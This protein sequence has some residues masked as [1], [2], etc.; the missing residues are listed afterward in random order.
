MMSAGSQPALSC[1]ATVKGIRQKRLRH[2]TCL[3]NTVEVAAFSDL[4]QGLA[5][6][7]GDRGAEVAGGGELVADE[8]APGRHWD[9]SPWGGTLRPR[10][11]AATTRAGSRWRNST[12]G[13]TRPHCSFDVKVPSWHTCGDGWARMRRPL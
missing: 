7:G 6:A 5:L 10:H 11:R 4:D 9:H 12:V 3:M 2:L 8:A 13:S 1:R